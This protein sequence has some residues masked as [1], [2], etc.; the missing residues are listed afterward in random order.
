MDAPH[1]RGASKTGEAVAGVTAN[2]RPLLWSIKPWR[3]HQLSVAMDRSTIAALV[4]SLAAIGDAQASSVPERENGTIPAPTARPAHAAARVDHDQAS[5]RIGSR[6]RSACMAALSRIAVI[7]A[8]RRPKAKDRACTVK[9]PV[10]MTA[11][12][13]RSGTVAISG[14]P[15]LD[16]PF[17]TALAGWT[18]EIAAPAA[19]RIVHR[20]LIRIET[21]PGFQCRRRNRRKTGKLSEHAFGNAVDIVGFEFSKGGFG[22]QPRPRGRYARYQKAMRKAACGWFTTTLGPGADA[23]HAT[24]LHL[25]LGRLYKNGKRRRNPY[26]LCR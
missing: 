15:T 2:E 23:A 7:E 19:K 17:A 25:D 16:C 13:T 3:T 12:R 6:D 26:R 20:R 24:H 10:R 11:V 18:R 5:P 14:A 4:L 9:A 21:G 1:A 22:I 8:V